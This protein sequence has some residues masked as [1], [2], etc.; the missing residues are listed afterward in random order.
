[1]ITGGTGALGMV[2]GSTLAEDGADVVLVD[3]DQERCNH[4]AEE[5]S[6]ATR[7]RVLGVRCDVADEGDVQSAV[8]R[9]VEAFGRIDIVINNAAAQ[10]PGFCTPFEE[11]PVEVWNRVMAVNLTGPFLMARAV[12]PVLLRQKSGSLINICST[13]GVVAPNQHLY[14]GSS[15][16]TPAVYSASKAG[17]LGLT[18]Y[19]ATYWAEKGIRVNSI[20]PGG[21]FRGHTDPFLAN[22]CARVP[23]ARMGQQ[24]E[25]RG[26]V[27]YLAS[28][29]SSYVT[30]HNLVVDG[31]WT[32]W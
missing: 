14:D 1:L 22:Y 2:F 27:V 19:L 15:F 8:R 23:M 17:I 9:A 31:G 32:T 24:D 4:C 29:A 7:R 18:R 10:P 16:N 20:T 13:Y 30:G 12:A 11:Y 6:S 25:L 26:A 21:I 3:V 5:I 28:D